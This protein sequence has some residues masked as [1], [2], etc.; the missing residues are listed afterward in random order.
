MS[1][2]LQALVRIPPEDAVHLLREVGPPHTPEH[3]ETLGKMLVSLLGGQAV[4]IPR[5]GRAYISIGAG[6]GPGLWVDPAYYED[7]D[8]DDD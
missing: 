2:E 6:L 7:Y 8:D 5:D 1:R 4:V 3:E